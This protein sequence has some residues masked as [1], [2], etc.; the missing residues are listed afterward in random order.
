MAAG[1][2]GLGG[3]GGGGLSETSVAKQGARGLL[4]LHILD[5]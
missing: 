4:H 3:E 2:G 1:R 5:T